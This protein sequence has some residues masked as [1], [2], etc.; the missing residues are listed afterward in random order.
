MLDSYFDSANGG[1]NTLQRKKQ[2]RIEGHGDTPDHQLSSMW[3]SVI[4]AIFLKIRVHLIHV[5]NLS[6]RSFR[7]VISNNIIIII[8]IDAGKITLS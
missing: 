1:Q 4:C 6:N 7:S 3:F 2:V 8:V 5:H